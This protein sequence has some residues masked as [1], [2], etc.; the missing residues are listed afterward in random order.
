ME[1]KTFISKP[2]LKGLQRNHPGLQIFSQWNTQRSNSQ[3]SNLVSEESSLCRTSQKFEMVCIKSTFNKKTQGHNPRTL[4]LYMIEV[5][6]AQWE[7]E[8]I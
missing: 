8:E 2:E 4:I 5:N 6:T 7:K 3:K 1:G